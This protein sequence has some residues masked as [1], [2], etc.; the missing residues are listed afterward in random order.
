MRPWT[1]AYCGATFNLHASTPCAECG[2][3]DII[4]LKE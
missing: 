2:S 3:I 4:D 1:C